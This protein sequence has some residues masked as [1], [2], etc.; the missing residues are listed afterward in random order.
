MT[1]VYTIG[2]SNRSI[3]DFIQLLR[4]NG[5]ELLVDI[6][7]IPKS[8]NNPQF[9]QGQLPRSLHA[10]GIEYRHLADLGGLRKTSSASVNTG[11]RNT[12]F[13]AYADYMQTEPFR[14]AVEDLIS[15][16]KERLTAI[17][18]AEAVPWR[19]HRSLVG[20]AL[21]IRDIDVADIMGTGSPRP[22][23]LTP[24]AVVDGTAVTYPPEE[25]AENERQLHPAPSD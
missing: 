8:R 16:A 23:K 6:R 1:T 22:H 18:C 10:A 14:H 15:M 20:D 19:C 11:W 3:D 24:F 25:G 13:R 12:S 17:M 2:H 21:L 4:D 5:V 9:G 7:T